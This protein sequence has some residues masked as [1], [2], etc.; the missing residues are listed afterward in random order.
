LLVEGPHGARFVS[1]K[2]EERQFTIPGGK[3]VGVVTTF[4]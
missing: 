3:S 2:L 1:L 4:L